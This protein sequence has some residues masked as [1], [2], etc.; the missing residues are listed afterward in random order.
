MARYIYL[1]L[2]LVG[3]AAFAHGQ[4]LQ[5]KVVDGSSNETLPFAEVT[6]WKDGVLV[7]GT[8]TDF[9]GN[10][11]LTAFDPGTYDVKIE[12]VGYSPKEIKG[13]VVG[14]S[15]TVPLDVEMG[16]GVDL[17]EIVVIEYV[18]PL[19]EADNT[20]GGQT[21]TA[22]DVE[23]LPTKSVSTLVGTTAG[24]SSNAR[25]GS[26]LSIRGSRSGDDIIYVDGVRTRGATVNAADVEQLQVITSGLPAEYGD[27]TGG[28]VSITTKGPSNKFAGSLEVETS[29]FLD[30][31]DF[32]F[33]NAAL[34]GP[35]LQKT[36]TKADGTEAKESIIG[37]RVS[38]QFTTL[39]DNVPGWVG[40]W[41]ATDEY[42]ALVESDPLILVNSGYVPR[43]ST[44]TTDDFTLEKAQ[45]NARGLDWSANA[46]LDFRLSKAIDV[47]LG[48]NYRGSK[49]RQGFD[50]WA[51]VNSARNPFVTERDTRGY[52]RFR[53]RI[54]QPSL[55]EDER[56]ENTSWIQNVYYTLQFDYSNTLDQQ[57][58]NVHEDRLF[59]YGHVGSWNNTREPVYATTFRP[60]I[61]PLDSLVGFS[62]NLGAFTAGAANP[63]LARWAEYDGINDNGLQIYNGIFGSALSRITV[64]N[65]MLHQNYGI[66]R[67]LYNKFE[68]NQYSFNAK[69]AFDLSKPGVE[70]PSKHSLQFGF[71]Y[72]QRIDRGYDIN[73]VGL[74]QIGD[75]LVNADIELDVSNPIEVLDEMGNVIRIDYNEVSTEAGT[76]AQSV[77]EQLGVASTDYVNLHGL[78]PSD[79][80]LDLFSANE[81]IAG[82]GAG[83]LDYW[84]HDYLGNKVSGDVSFSDFFT[85]RDA[86][87]DLLR[88][89]APSQPIYTAAYIQDKFTFKDIYFNVGVRVDRFDANQEVL[90]DPFVLYGTRSVAESGN[91]S[92]SP[93]AQPDWT[94]YVDNIDNPQSV[95]A[96]RDGE[97]WYTAGGTAVNGANA[98]FGGTRPSPYLTNGSSDN[99]KN[100]D[101]DPSL[102][103]EDY[104]PQV[105]IMPRVA[106]SFPISED[107]GFFAHYDVLTR[108][109]EGRFLATALDYY[110]FENL[111][112]SGGIN[113][114]NLK[115]SKTVDFEIG[116]QQRVSNSSAIK[117][118]AYYKELRDMV[119]FRQYTFAYPVST[120]DSYDNL[121]FGTVKGFSFQYD[122]RRTK[123]LRL[124]ANYTLQFAEGTGSSTTS[125]RGAS[126]R[127]N[128]RVIF[129]FDYDQRHTFNGIVDYRYGGGDK[130][131]GPKIG[132]KNILANTGVN[133][134][135]KVASGRPF[136]KTNRPVPFDG[137]E[138]VGNLNGAR[139]PWT[140]QIDIRVDK[141]I[142]IGGKDGKKPLSLNVFARSQNLLN[143]G[144]VV[145]VYSY[146]QSATDD[147]YLDSAEG[148]QV[149]NGQID[150]AAFELLY[151]LRLKNNGL[152]GLPRRIRIGAI[153]TF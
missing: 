76:F 16:V 153:L 114:P 123:N 81:I 2:L 59:D 32:N 144:N 28:I 25:E 86:R 119:Q 100:D 83:F 57:Q 99:I 103:F 149:L 131:T 33:V 120:Y 65:T 89:V 107:A 139:L 41:K 97:Q 47:T 7:T 9:D 18:V 79:L 17:T 143:T 146:T 132:G 71:L 45:P 60:G 148:T 93:N 12:Y 3:C 23:R 121:D 113:N 6:I 91:L 72:E 101:F 31:F 80:S 124:V 64:E 151:G 21:L 137:T 75:Q 40:S 62:T 48:G 129:P 66:P 34:S 55:D 50:S 51:L 37:F 5:G 84:G 147:G 150:P 88:P 135:L 98:I 15:K 46:K 110:F 128:L 95:T 58:D 38:G 68:T 30:P 109:P 90:K 111:V 39:G 73:P 26:G 140:S 116:F 1:I 117:L 104:E 145:G 125:Q 85:Q 29:E 112:N 63:A 77:R 92:H 70:N 36:V 74:W 118:S 115:P 56:S 138:T 82:G 134:L 20:V 8:Q 27:V 67:D 44:I 142:Q 122:M 141:D 4:T 87:G 108:R 52:L 35:I 49:D 127:G 24:I 105:N 133:L 43:I 19:I 13:V 61:G 53:H 22:D 94:V 130:Y 11:N 106:F 152:Y 42:Q 54:S 126:S 136:T 69:G 14:V 102:S 78:N 96:Y 10:Y